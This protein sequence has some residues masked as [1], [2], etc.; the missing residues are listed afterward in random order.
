MNF[1]LRCTRVLTIGLLSWFASTPALATDVAGIKLE[2]TISLGGKTLKLNGAGV[3]VKFFAK[4]YVAGLYLAEEKKSTAEVIAVAGPKRIALTILREL[5]SEQLSQAFL[6]GI[7]QN[8]T[9]DEKIKIMPQLIN[10]GKGFTKANAVKKGDVITMDWLP[11]GGTII[12]LNGTQL[13]DPLPG[14]E[15]YEALLKIWLGDKPVDSTLKKKLLNE[16]VE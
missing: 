5:S 10:F 2:S 12:Q 8:S 15:F 14:V 9:K 1:I 11:S 16:A 7:G 4:V 13:M 6:D 3:R